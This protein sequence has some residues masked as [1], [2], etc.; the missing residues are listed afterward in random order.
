MRRLYDI[1][2]ILAAAGCCEKSSAHNLLWLGLDRIPSHL[3][4]VAKER[5]ISTPGTT[6]TDLFPVTHT[7]GIVNLTVD[8]LLLYFTLRTSHLDL[9]MVATLLSRNSNS[10]RSTLCKLYQVTFVLCA[11]GITGRTE[12]TCHVVLMPQYLFFEVLPV[13]KKEPVDPVDPAT[14]LNP[15]EGSD[16]DIVYRR[17]NEFQRLWE[18]SGNNRTSLPLEDTDIG[19]P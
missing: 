10:F 19:L 9:R 8:L 3:H 2:N 1:I 18:A 5:G 13:E 11:A 16:T 12:L 6:F 14:M 17:R 4:T 7:S 15:R